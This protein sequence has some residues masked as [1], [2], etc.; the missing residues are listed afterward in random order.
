MNQIILV[1]SDFAEGKAVLKGRRLSH[2]REILGKDKG[3][4]VKAGILGGKKGTAR[5]LGIDDDRAILE[6]VLDQDPPEKLPLTL[7]VAMQRPKVLGRMLQCAAALGVSRIYIIRTWRT[8]KSYFSNSI[9]SPDNLREELILGLEQSLDTILPEIHLRKRFRPFVED[10]IP[11][12]IKNSVA[13]VAHPYSDTP[14]TRAPEGMPVT[15]A[16][17]PEGGFIPFEIELLTAQ[18]F[19]PVSLG[20]RI[21]RTEQAFPF[22]VGKIF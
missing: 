6:P 14:C 20:E 4:L 5:I 19:I 9:L 18:G 21:L 2:M 15:L 7:I 8:E 3:D 22:L 10:E 17:G 13:L 1:E 12:I 11:A 16:L